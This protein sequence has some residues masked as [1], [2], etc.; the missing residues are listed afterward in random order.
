V[1]F[2]SIDRN[3][4][5]GALAAALAMAARQPAAGMTEAA[6]GPEPG[7][8]G[9]RHLPSEAAEAAGREAEVARSRRPESRPAAL[10]CAT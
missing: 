6:M 4:S 5:G 2:I 10:F 3:L 8:A 7:V 9:P 1:P